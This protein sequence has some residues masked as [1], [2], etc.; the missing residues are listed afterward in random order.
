VE[1]ERLGECNGD[2]GKP[3]MSDVRGEAAFLGFG[4]GVVF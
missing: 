4:L 1:I 2:I 3:V